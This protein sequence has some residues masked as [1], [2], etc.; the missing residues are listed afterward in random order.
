MPVAEILYPDR[1]RLVTVSELL[2]KNLE[3]TGR[4]HVRYQNGFESRIKFHASNA[5]AIDIGN[6]DVVLPP[7]GWYQHRT[8]VWSEFINYAVATE[9]AVGATGS[10]MSTSC[11]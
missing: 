1:Q 3:H 10:R 6:R 9:G 2:K 8:E 4:I 11:W 7:Y 5:W